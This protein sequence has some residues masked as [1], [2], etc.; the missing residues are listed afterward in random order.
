MKQYNQL[1]KR[2]SMLDILYQHIAKPCFF[3]LD[4]ETAHEAAILA[5]RCSR[6][7]RPMIESLLRVD[8]SRLRRTIWGMD[9][10]NP[11]GLAGGFDKN[12]RVMDVWPCFGFSFIEIGAVTPKPQPGNPKPRIFRYPKMEALVNRMGFNNDGVEVIAQRLEALRQRGPLKARV[13]V[14][15]GKQFDTPVDDLERVIDD[16]RQSASRLRDLC[17][18]FV[19]NVSSPNTPNLRDLQNA[20][21]LREILL[22]VRSVLL[23]PEGKRKPLLVKISPDLDDSQLEETIAAASGVPVDG[24]IATNTTIRAQGVESGGLSGRPLRE[25]STEVVRRVARLT[26]GQM[27]IIGCGGVFDAFDALEKLE[28]GAWLI[29]LYTGFVYR[30]PTVAR[31]ILRGLLRIMDERDCASIA[32]IARRSDAHDEDVSC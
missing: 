19:V 23:D 9:F 20:E 32:D 5:L 1:E 28:A 4:P 21:S 11:I 22:S 10:L 30:G 16:Y 6:P 13:G 3:R 31:D 2:P 8:D 12:A 18:F 26:G 7:V 27:P 24:V 15:L 14:N 29:Q 25:R 17:D